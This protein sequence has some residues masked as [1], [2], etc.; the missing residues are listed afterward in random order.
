[1]CHFCENVDAQCMC[2]FVC[3]GEDVFVDVGLYVSVHV[4]V[5]V[6]LYVSVHVFVDVSA[7][8]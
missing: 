3:V 2:V 6:G 1:M 8:F 4:F 5:D 7:Y